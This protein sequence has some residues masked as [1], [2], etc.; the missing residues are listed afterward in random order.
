MTETSDTVTRLS[1]DL[2]SAATTLSDAEARFLVDSYYIIQEDRKRT[3]NQ[4]LAMKAEPHDLLTW[5]K[6]QN[7][8]LEKQIAVALDKYSASKP[9]G[10]WMRSQYGIG[11]VI[12][13]GLM[14]HI[15]IK[16]ASTAGAI[17]RFAGLDP[18]MKWE[19]GQ[20][21]PW[22]ADLKTLCWKIGQSFMKFSGQE[23]CFYGK[24]YLERKKYEVARN[25]RMD[26]KELALSLAPRFNKS[27]DAYKH[28]MEG[29]LPPAQIDARARRWAVKIFLSHVQQVWWEMDTGEKP[30]KPF[31]IA[32]LGH[33]HEIPIPN[34]P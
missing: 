12:A 17:W 4:V 30:P 1:K 2:R 14:A 16:K 25:D 31:P 27:T 7:A 13:A 23:E 20:K 26:N 3:G 24:L 9:I 32:H 19:K 22:N 21:R 11:P 10:L 34:K 33:A 8:V 29:K 18:T 5:F 28:L 15:D 6:D